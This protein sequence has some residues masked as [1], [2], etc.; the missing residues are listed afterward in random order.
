MEEGGQVWQRG[1]QGQA[2]IGKEKRRDGRTHSVLPTKAKKLMSRK[3]QPQ[4]EQEI[5]T[6][7]SMNEIRWASRKQLLMKQD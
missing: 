2:R 6:K 5:N 7:V 4:R 1:W 3:D